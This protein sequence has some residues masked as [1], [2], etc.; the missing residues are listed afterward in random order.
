MSC[1]TSNNNFI[2]FEE[3]QAQ[4]QKQIN[5]KVLFEL[6][7][8]DTPMLALSSIATQSVHCFQFKFNRCFRIFK[9]HCFFHDS[10]LPKQGNLVRKPNFCACTFCEVASSTITCCWFNKTKCWQLQISE[11]IENIAAAQEQTV[12]TPKMFKSFVLH[13][14]LSKFLL[15][16][17]TDCS[18]DWKT[19]WRTW[20][21]T[22][23][24]K[25]KHTFCKWC[26]PT[27]LGKL[28]NFSFAF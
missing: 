28:A 24:M 27:Q 22:I 17:S 19:W 4:F 12:L 2:T 6:V 7:V 25:L 21:I 1:G 20:S 23:K 8:D 3:Q 18:S 9:L 26:F 10:L 11:T 16:E 14:S 13:C 15:N 5:H